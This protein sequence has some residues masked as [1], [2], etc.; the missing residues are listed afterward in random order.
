MPPPDSVQA[1]SKADALRTQVE[2]SRTRMLIGHVPRAS[3]T[4]GG[5]AILIVIMASS[6]VPRLMSWPVM[7]WLFAAVTVSLTRTAHA[8]AYLRSA[9]RDAPHWRPTFLAFTLCLSLCWSLLPWTLPLRQHTDL[10]SAVIG[11]MI[12]MAATG[13]SM[14]GFD[15]VHTRAWIGPLLASAALYCLTM[16]GPLGWFGAISVL[17]FLVILWLESN[18][19]HRRIAEML[20]LRYE[21]EQLAQARAQ[22]LKEAESLSSAKERFLTTMSHEMRT[23]LHGILGLSRMLRGELTDSTAQAQMT[24]LQNAGEHLLGVINDVLDFSRVK[25]NKLTLKPRAIDLHG[26]VHDVCHLADV[27]ARDKGVVV[28]MQSALPDATWVEAD[29]DRLRQI[30]TN[31]VGNAVKFTPQGHV[32]VRLK[33]GQG[34]DA[35]R[36]EVEDTGPG[37]PPDQCA[38][39]F[40]PFHQVDN[41]DERSQG[42]TGLG[43]S[44]AQQICMAMAG[45]IHCESRPGIG[46]TFWFVLPLPRTTPPAP[47]HDATG[48]PATDTLPDEAVHGTVL[49]VEDNPVNALVARATLERLGLQVCVAD[50]G[51][52]ALDWL[53]QHRADL[54]LMD[55]HMPEMGGVEATRRIRAIEARRGLPAIPIVAVS[56]G[57]HHSDDHRECLAAGMN[58]YLS[59]PFTQPDMVRILHRHLPHAAPPIAPAPGQLAASPLA[60]QP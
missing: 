19:A 31:L 20:R 2:F 32:I 60:V 4:V 18:R 21:S 36:F 11:S 1:A 40:E 54:I 7:V 47:A 34:T 33:P 17:G 29:P 37:I 35:I 48:V 16:A 42:G 49:V 41:R 14:L 55:C 45:E 22:A 28:T 27:T 24:L 56:A 51:Q 3:L 12:G 39:V 15:R 58:D 46:S 59:K 13:A 50:N 57:N 38:K 8:I 25:A 23:P 53:T 6:L 52:R 5:F 10:A 30:L 26:L 44:I 43:L 9:R